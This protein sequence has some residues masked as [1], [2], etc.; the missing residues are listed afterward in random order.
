MLPVLPDGLLGEAVDVDRDTGCLGSLHATHAP[1]GSFAISG[2]DAPHPHMIHPD[3]ANRSVLQTDLGQDRFYVYRFDRQSG[4]L[5]PAD[6]PFISLPT[7]DGPRHFVFHPHR[8][9]MYSIQE[10][11]SMI[12]FFHYQPETGSLTPQQSVSNLPKRFT[13]TNFCSA[14]MV[15]IE[16]R[17]C[18]RPTGCTPPSQSSQ[19][20]PRDIWNGLEKHGHGAIIRVS[21]IWIPAAH[22]CMYATNGTTRLPRFE[23]TRR[24]DC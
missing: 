23:S 20:A 19:S 6:T 5:G 17:F 9:W 11:A 18:K 3:P 10:E 7:G 16:A 1:T 22:F 12:V 14:I 13:W 24:P 2:H 8:G 15:S 4:Q 21:S